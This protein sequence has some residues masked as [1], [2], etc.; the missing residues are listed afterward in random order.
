MIKHMYVYIYIYIYSLYVVAT[1][2]HD[3]DVILVLNRG[4]CIPLIVML[5]ERLK[6][7]L[8]YH[9]ATYDNIVYI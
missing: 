7:A 5:R 4:E 9:E 6:Y 1:A 8:T 3:N 2:N